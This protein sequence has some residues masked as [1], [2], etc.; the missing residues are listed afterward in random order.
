MENRTANR[1]VELPYVGVTLLVYDDV[2]DTV[3][4]VAEVEF[5]DIIEAAERGAP[6][7]QCQM[8]LPIS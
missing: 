8:L 6:L 7:A 2:V 3:A 4:T 1:V 5:V